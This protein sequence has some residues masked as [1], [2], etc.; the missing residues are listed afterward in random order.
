MSWEKVEGKWRQFVGEAKQKWGKL[1]DDD[2][3]VI[4]GKRDKLVGKIQEHYDL[5]KE[6]AEAEVDKWSAGL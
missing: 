4:D 3:D 2:M 6:E 1:T 5:A